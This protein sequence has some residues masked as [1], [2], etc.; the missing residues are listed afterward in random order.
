MSSRT[1]TVVMV[2]ARF[3]PLSF[4]CFSGCEL[5]QAQACHVV[6]ESFGTVST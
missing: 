3:F 2:R 5:N 6:Q 1:A 4:F